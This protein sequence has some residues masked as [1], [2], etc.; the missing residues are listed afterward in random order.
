MPRK[1]YKRKPF[2]PEIS[3]GGVYGLMM[4]LNE[5]YPPSSSLCTPPD[6]PSNQGFYV[7]CKVRT[8]RDFFQ[9]PKGATGTIDEDY[10]T[11]F[12]VK[13][14]DYGFRDGFDKQNELQWL[15]RI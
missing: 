13:W 12:M 7:G 10:G 9:L 14:D 4:A 8:N 11:G 15:E 2:E 6:A 3:M 5:K 1:S